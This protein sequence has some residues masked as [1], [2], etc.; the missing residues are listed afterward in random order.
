M[1]SLGYGMGYSFLARLMTDIMV[2]SSAKRSKGGR[3]QSSRGLLAP[4]P[5]AND[6]RTIIG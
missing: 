5:R 3:G 4:L 1:N 6:V 2:A